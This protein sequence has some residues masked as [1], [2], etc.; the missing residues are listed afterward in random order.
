MPQTTKKVKI[1][2]L[3]TGD[4][5]WIGGL[6][7]V[8]NLLKA[9]SLQKS[10]TLSFIALTGKATPKEIIGVLNE[11]K[12]EH[13]NLDDFSMVS[14]VLHRYPE[15]I[16]RRIAKLRIDLVFPILSPDPIFMQGPAKAI[17]WIPDFQHKFY[18]EFFTQSELNQRDKAQSQIA[19]LNNTLV[20][21]SQDALNH[22][23]QF[24]PHHKCKTE[25]LRFR[26]VIA[27]NELSET[28][29]I[30]GKYPV[31]APY[32]MVCNQFWKHKNHR[33]IIDAAR[34]LAND[35]LNY[36]IIIT[37]KADQQFPEVFEDIKSDIEKYHLHAIHLVGFISRADQLQLMNQCLAVIQPSKFEGW[38]TV[39][40]DAR[41]LGVR[42][43][44][45]NLAVNHEQMKDSALYFDTDSAP[46]LASLMRGMLSNSELKNKPEPQNDFNDYSQALTLIFSK[47][48]E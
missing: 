20:L 32:F 22:F 48:A 23:K 41:T 7:Y 18:P 3:L 10:D 1:G 11:Y 46:Q 47:I 45:A 34:I 9:L 17:F 6:Y 38:S 14:R 25:L 43:I 35:G 2:F 26:S 29:H 33:L 5:L 40:E 37:G 39:N 30:A 13:N 42:V 8:L 44:A 36:S 24:Y 19:A 15:R 12:I 31:S 16:K 4:Y 21:S 27:S 28:H